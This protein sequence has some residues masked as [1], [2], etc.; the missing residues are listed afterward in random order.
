M[1]GVSEARAALERGRRVVLVAP[2][3]PEHATTLWEVIGAPGE[4]LDTIIVCADRAAAL[5]WA[6]AAPVGVTLHSVT[7]LER[8]AR[9]LQSGAVQV[10]AGSLDDL[11]Q[12]V[13]RTVLKPATLATVVVAWPEGFPVEARASVDSLLGD[14][15]EARRVILSWNPPAVRD[16]LDRHA[17]KAPVVGDVP[18]DDTARPLPPVAPARYAIVT[19]DA[20]LAAIRGALDVLD[21]KSAVM[22][23]PDETHAERLAGVLGSGERGAGLSVETEASGAAGDLIVCARVPSR[24]QFAALAARGPVLLLLTPSQLGYA[25]FIASP[26]TAVRLPGAV[27]RAAD[28]A[29]ALR[30]RIATRLEAGDVDAEL[31]LLEPLFE[32]FDP[33]EV[34]AA[35]VALERGAGSGEPSA[36]AVGP[37][38]AFVKIF[39]NV[40][41]KDRAGPKDL[42]G[43]LIKEVGLAK[44]DLGRIELR[45][46]FSTV[47]VA[48]GVVDDVLKKLVG[49]TIRGRRVQ[50]RRDR[51]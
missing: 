21:P 1:T 23:T 30:R 48:A 18:Q 44:A 40:G 17:F 28:A 7:G 47:E 10:L 4:G 15:A 9:L 42:V 26:L 51:G 37:A 22:W 6:N 45:E 20:R 25:R 38:P 27:D 50:A 11:T 32:R 43:A 2:P 24:E 8:A 5:D 13:G 14:A 35:L 3:A 34:A 33:A 19:P 16:F 46:T 41:K 29:E 31:L 36:P 49:V 12:L 39:V